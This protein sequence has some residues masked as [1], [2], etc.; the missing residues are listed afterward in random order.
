MPATPEMTAVAQF[1][2][3]ELTSAERVLLNAVVDGHVATVGRDAAA[4]RYREDTARTV[5]GELVRWVLTEPFVLDALDPGG[6]GCGARAWLAR[7]TSP[8]WTFRC[9]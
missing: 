2:F 3:G 4:F 1:R 8:A 5:R 6:L 7:S 9:G